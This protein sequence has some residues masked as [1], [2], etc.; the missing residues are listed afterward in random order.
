MNPRPHRIELRLRNTMALFNSMDPSP[1]PEKDLDDEAEAFIVSWARELPANVPITL[2]VHLEERPPED[3]TAMLTEAVR[4]YFRYRSEMLH[5]EFRQLMR[6]ARTSLLI[7]LTFLAACL[8][9]GR[10]LLPEDGNTLTTFLRESLI[11]A[12]WVAMWRPIELYLY[13]WWPLRRKARLHERL[14]GMHVEVVL[15]A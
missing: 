9:V 11:I 6:Q 12:G 5:R 8:V 10:Y 2:R 3:P 14:A 7:G 1:F 13:D 15:P 4:N